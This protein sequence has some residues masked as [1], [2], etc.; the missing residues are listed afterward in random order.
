[1]RRPLT[2]P[3]Q[4]PPTLPQLDYTP[5]HKAAEQGSTEVAVALMER[6]ATVDA[7]DRVSAAFDVPDRY[8]P[9]VTRVV[10]WRW[11]AEGPEGGLCE[12]LGRTFLLVTAVPL[13]T[14]FPTSHPCERSLP[15]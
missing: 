13:G 15:L 2:R 11:S 5:L 12:M 10:W 9:G 6:G 3:P 14:A 8:S 1:M 4:P 7:K